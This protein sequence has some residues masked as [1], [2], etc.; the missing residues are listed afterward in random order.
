MAHKVSM[1]IADTIDVGHV[2]VE[3]E[4]RSGRGVVGHDDPQES[5]FGIPHAVVSLPTGSS[6]ILTRELL[7]T[8]VTRGNERFTV[9]VSEGAL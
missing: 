9:V 3:F 7:S 4:V 1:K 8:A 6:P 2:E 5:G